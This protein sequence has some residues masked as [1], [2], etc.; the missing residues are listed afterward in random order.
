MVLVYQGSGI[1]NHFILCFFLSKMN[2]KAWSLKH[3]HFA[4][5]RTHVFIKTS[6]LDPRDDEG[7][8]LGGLAKKGVRKKKN[9]K[10]SVETLR[11][12][13]KIKETIVKRKKYLPGNTKQVTPIIDT[14][15]VHARSQ[16]SNSG[17][18]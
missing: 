5:L 16:E 6:S 7:A 3:L 4:F 11:G 13:P 8:H 10:K 1:P 14:E 2:P 12:N 9:K 18:D 17:G 15:C